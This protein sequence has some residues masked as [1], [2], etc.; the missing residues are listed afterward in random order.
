M[1]VNKDFSI[2]SL[3]E[4]NSSFCNER[5]LLTINKEFKQ[6]EISIFV[7]SPTEKDVLYDTVRFHNQEHINISSQQ[8]LPY[9][10]IGEVLKK[11]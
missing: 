7:T 10:S 4:C 6:L 9:F 5:A 11:N 8:R 1:L 2:C 3:H